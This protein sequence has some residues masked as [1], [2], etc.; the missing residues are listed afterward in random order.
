MDFLKRI[1]AWD[2]HAYA[3]PVWWFINHTIAI[4][5]LLVG[6]SYYTIMPNIHALYILLGE[7]VNE[8]NV[9]NASQIQYQLFGRAQLDVYNN[10]SFGWSYWTLKND[11]VHWDFEWNIKNKYLSLGIHTCTSFHPIVC[12]PFLLF[13]RI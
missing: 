9:P 1:R 12:R 4:L 6:Y 10:A 3:D 11:R 5:P 2:A 7:W 13:S 8:W